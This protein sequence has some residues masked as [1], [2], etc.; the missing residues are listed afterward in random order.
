MTQSSA[1]INFLG[2]NR[3]PHCGTAGFNGADAWSYSEDINKNISFNVSKVQSG[4][5]APR[6]VLFEGN[7]IIIPGVSNSAEYIVQTVTEDASYF[8]VT[9]SPTDINNTVSTPYQTPVPWFSISQSCPEIQIYFTNE[10]LR[11][12]VEIQVY[13]DSVPYHWKVSGNPLLEL[14]FFGPNGQ[15]A[16]YA[17]YN[18]SYSSKNNYLEFH[19]AIEPTDIGNF[20]IGDGFDYPI[21]NDAENKVYWTYYNNTDQNVFVYPPDLAFSDTSKVRINTEV[22]SNSGQ[23]QFTILLKRSGTPGKIPTKDDLLCGELA[24]NTVD[25]KLFA[26]KLDDEI[27]TV[28]QSAIEYP[29]VDDLPVSGQTDVIYMTADKNKLYRWDEN[30]YYVQISSIE[31]QIFT[32][33][34]YSISSTQNNFNISNYSTVRVST[35]SSGLGIT[36]FVAGQ[37]GEIRLIY[38]G[39]NYAIDIPHNSGLSSSGNKVL[40]YNSENFSLEVNAGITILYDAA[41]NS[42]TGA[43]RLF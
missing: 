9:A 11:V 5:D 34:N 8:Y 4:E 24:M 37:D 22:L 26:K 21:I 33:G 15:I 6:T 2:T 17:R 41:Y 43:W 23:G 31:P 40:I 38:N 7:K 27:I 36:G 14:N 29:T 25:G 28:G 13:H 1:V 35:T 10:I 12:R 3:L 42:N 18:D 32:V 16:K 19:Y 30:E 39:G 20:A